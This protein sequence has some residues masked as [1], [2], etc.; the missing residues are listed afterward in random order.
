MFYFEVRTVIV[1][2]SYTAK[3]LST[4]R[5]HRLYKMTPQHVEPE[6]NIQ[7]DNEQNAPIAEQNAPIHGEP[8][9]ERLALWARYAARL[10]GGATQ[11]T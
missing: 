8:I 5:T 7:Q 3:T 1:I 4:Y 9:A 11:T 6:N 10:L 2:T